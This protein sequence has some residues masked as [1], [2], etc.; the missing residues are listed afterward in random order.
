MTEI[1]LVFRKIVAENID[2]ISNAL[3]M[4]I[5]VEVSDRMIE[6]IAKEMNMEFEAVENHFYLA[7]KKFEE[8]LN[9]DRNAN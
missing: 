9:K 8:D 2:K 7:S 4:K 3:I 6:G 5:V 1:E